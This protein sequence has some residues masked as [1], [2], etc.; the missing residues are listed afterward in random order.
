MMR[1][2]MIVDRPAGTAAHRMGRLPLVRGVGVDV[3]LLT[4]G[5][6]LDASVSEGQRFW[7]PPLL[8]SV[9][10]PMVRRGVR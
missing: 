7:T 2:T 8:P 1:R 3:M 6:P 9:S 10:L 5:A 4:D